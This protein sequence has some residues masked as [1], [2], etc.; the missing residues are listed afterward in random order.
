V[1]LDGGVVEHAVISPSLSIT[2]A[3]PKQTR[4]ECIRFRFLTA[5]SIYRGE[6]VRGGREFSVD[7]PGGVASTRVAI[8]RDS[9]LDV[10]RPV[11]YRV[12]RQAPA[13]MKLRASRSA[14]VMSDLDKLRSLAA[15]QGAAHSHFCS[16]QTLRFAV[17]ARRAG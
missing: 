13:V 12:S 14:R 9:R 5:G 7:A 10:D 2:F 16:Q 8:A 6:F 1:S 4:H 17:C 3:A 15:R 11:L